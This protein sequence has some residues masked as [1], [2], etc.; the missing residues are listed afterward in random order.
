MDS[1]QGE[2]EYVYVNDWSMDFDDGVELSEDR[3]PETREVGGRG[4]L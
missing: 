3:K 1:E 2:D 4:Y